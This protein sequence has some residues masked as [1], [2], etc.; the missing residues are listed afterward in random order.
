MVRLGIVD[1]AFGGAL[2]SKTTEEAYSLLE[3]MLPIVTNDLMSVLW[4]RRLPVFIR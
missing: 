3:E 1:T 4:L 2:I